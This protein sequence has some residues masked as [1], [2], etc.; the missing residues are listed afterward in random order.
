MLKCTKH[1]IFLLELDRGIFKACE[2]ILYMLQRGRDG[3]GVVAIRGNDAV[4]LL[5]VN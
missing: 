4:K 2:Q 5:A 1:I 3:D